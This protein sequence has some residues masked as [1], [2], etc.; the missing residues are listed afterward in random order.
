M[1]RYHVRMRLALKRFEIVLVFLV[2]MVCAYFLSS[3]FFGGF[4]GVS[5][6]TL[7]PQPTV[8][9]QREAVLDALSK[10]SGP[11]TVSPTQREQIL[12]TLAASSSAKTLPSM[13]DRMRVLEQLSKKR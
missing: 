3:Y 12:N 10:S 8:L 2:A 4:S 11:P 7:I 9:N 13:E 1:V 6:I 5:D